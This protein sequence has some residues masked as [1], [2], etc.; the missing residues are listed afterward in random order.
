MDRADPLV[1][2]DVYTLEFD[3]DAVSWI[4]PSRHRIRV[5]ISGA[6]FPEVFPAPHPC[7]LSVYSGS[8][9]PSRLT[10]PVVPAGRERQE[11]VL[12]Q[13]PARRSQFTHAGEQAQVAVIYDVT[14]RMMIAR[15][16][17]SDALRRADG[18]EV[19]TE[20]LME[21]A[22]PATDPA[23]AVVS[24]RDRKRLQRPGLDVDSVATADLRGDAS[25]LQLHLTLQVTYNGA[26]YWSREW[27]RTIPRAL[28]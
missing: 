4:F 2:G 7:E 17:Q 10:L 5:A 19:T 12:R 1:P 11:P 3:L 20:N 22:V 6:D 21:I 23:G 25:A 14:R 24:G 13:P 18:T 15:R 16:E 27:R 26:P 8:N 28:L 9:H